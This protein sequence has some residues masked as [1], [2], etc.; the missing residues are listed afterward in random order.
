MLFSH[1]LPQDH[2]VATIDAYIRQSETSLAQLAEAEADPKTP[3]ERFVIG[4]GRAV[5]VAILDFLRA[6]RREF[7]S[8]RE[9]AE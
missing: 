8:E 9:A 5:Y 6:H 1:L 4:Y 7:E 2:V 3:G